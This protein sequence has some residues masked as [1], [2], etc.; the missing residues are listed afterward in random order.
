MPAA[1][2]LDGVQVLDGGT[3]GIS[4]LPQI[5]DREAVLVLDAV[6][7][8]ATDPGTV[9]VLHENEVACA[10]SLMVSDHQLGITEALAA[11]ELAGCHPR[12]LTAV[13]MVPADLDTG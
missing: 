1:L 10:R 9:V 6:A 4:L 13:G 5:T 8:Q 12:R 2:A 3:L 7:A 11:A